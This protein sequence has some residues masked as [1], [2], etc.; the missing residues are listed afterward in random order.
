MTCILTTFLP[1]PP[2]QMLAFQV[3][4]TSQPH[5]QFLIPFGKLLFN[6]RKGSLSSELTKIETR[7]DLKPFEVGV[8]YYNSKG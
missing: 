5:N 2:S 6:P 7:L 1:Q 8:S 4:T 3:Y